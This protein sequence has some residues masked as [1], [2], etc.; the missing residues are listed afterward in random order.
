[1]LSLVPINHS[2]IQ[3]IRTSP[4]ASIGP[5]ELKEAHLD[6]LG[7]LTWA[8]Y[9]SSVVSSF[10]WASLNTCNVCTDVCVCRPAIIINPLPQKCF[11]EHTPNCLMTILPSPFPPYLQGFI[12]VKDSPGHYWNP[13]V[14]HSWG[15]CPVFPGILQVGI[16][17]TG[18]SY[19]QIVEPCSSLWIILVPIHYF[20]NYHM[21]WHIQV[22]S[23]V[24]IF[25]KRSICCFIADKFCAF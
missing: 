8:R 12:S 9:C 2:I 14:L 10:S 11:P 18:S 1:M 17:Q 6:Y 19:S 24:F 22:F 3:F 15:V 21:S 23:S 7:R 16:K 20:P 13:F 5:G 4:S 25:E